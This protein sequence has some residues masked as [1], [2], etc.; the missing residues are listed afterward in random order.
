MEAIEYTEDDAVWDAHLDAL[1]E[2]GN[3]TEHMLD[4]VEVKTTPK[5]KVFWMSDW[6]K[7]D[8]LVGSGH[9]CRVN[10]GG[11]SYGHCDYYVA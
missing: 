1:A 9:L 2:P 6:N 7:C 3:D 8:K 5:G 10:L 11:A 4:G